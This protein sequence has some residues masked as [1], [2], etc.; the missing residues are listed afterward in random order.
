ML[1]CIHEGIHQKSS[2]HPERPIC[3]L[4][5]WCFTKFEGEARVHI[6]GGVW[7]TQFQPCRRLETG[8]LS[9]PAEL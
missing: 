3:M 2:S 6:S 9:A 7:I 4:R 5:F 1:P 8:F